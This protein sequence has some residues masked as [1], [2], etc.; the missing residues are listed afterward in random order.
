VI[1]ACARSA[2]LAGLILLAGCYSLTN[3]Q[4][5]EVL[6]AGNVAVGAGL[7]SAFSTRYSEYPSLQ[8]EGDILVRCGLGSNIDVGAKISGPFG[9]LAADAKWQIASSPMAR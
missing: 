5:P 1:V 6:P 9:S 3:F 4:S 2:L 7:A 8:C